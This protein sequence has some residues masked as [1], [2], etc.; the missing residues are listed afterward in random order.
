M[1]AERGEVGTLG[2]EPEREGHEERSTRAVTPY[3]EQPAPPPARPAQATA[4]ASFR[5][6]QSFVAELSNEE[7]LERSKAL[8]HAYDR[9]CEALIGPNDQQEAEG[10][11]FKKKSAWRKLGRHF[12]ISVE[13][14]TEPHGRWERFPHDDA[15]HYVAF[16]EVR[17]V[18][19]WG[20]SMPGFGACS[21]RERRF[22]QH[23]PLCPMCGGSMWDNRQ[24]SREGAFAC[25]D[26]KY[27]GHVLQ[28][29]QYTE[30]ELGLVP[31]PGARAKAEHDCMA[32]AQTRAINRAIS[33]LIAM[34]EVSWEEVEGTADGAGSGA[35]RAQEGSG[36][37]RQGRT[38][39]GEGKGQ[40]RAPSL[41]DTVPFGRNKGKTWR[42]LCQEDPKDA[43]W[44]VDKSEKLEEPVK[45][46]LRE[47]L[48][49]L[50]AEHQQQQ[51]AESSQE[52]EPRDPLQRTVPGGK[53]KGK[54]WLEAVQKDP[55]YFKGIL[56]RGHPWMEENVPPGS[57]LR[58]GVEVVLSGEPV[59]ALSVLR[60]WL[61]T[62]GGDEEWLQAYAEV[63][64]KLPS[65]LE[66][67]E[68]VHAMR[69]LNEARRFGWPE[70]LGRVERALE[71]GGQV[72]SANGQEPEPP[73][74]E[75]S[76]GGEPEPPPVLP[77]KVQERV[78]STLGMAARHHLPDVKEWRQR[79][80]E[81]AAAGEAKAV[82]N[83]VGELQQVIYQHISRGFSPVANAVEE[84]QERLPF[85]NE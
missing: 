16:A 27:C 26:R 60:R 14:T 55:G 24:D 11:S 7:S 20:Q 76:F 1:A 44:Y 9:A 36:R 40:G 8:A 15:A 66:E 2:A 25:R 30:E 47:H 75:P 46:L 41:D 71:K 49:A 37:P 54:S 31:N 10:R 35:Q 78:D 3:R 33:E 48:E 19:P 64:P 52:E 39:R 72:D 12:F 83:V 79:L 58:A 38:A 65:N 45:E 67:W 77:R 32:T 73:Q 63:H 82:E 43:R 62:A 84:A 13:A 85:L 5:D 22:Y 74:E 34:G 29:G 61:Y 68:E 80:E 4:P 51:H 6:F 81:V 42:Q 17:A 59:T 18:A 28:E 69:G 23:G 53:F 50:E 70:L 21:T 57:E 56:E